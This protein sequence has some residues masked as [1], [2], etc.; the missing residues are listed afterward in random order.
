[1][2]LTD[3]RRDAARRKLPTIVFA[4]L[5]CCACVLVA[6]APVAAELTDA[7]A[8]GKLIYPEGKSQSNRG[9]R[10]SIG[11]AE[12]PSSATILPCVQCHGEN[13]RGIGIVTSKSL[14]AGSTPPRMA[15]TSEA[16]S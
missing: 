6:R 2:P 4:L 13:G 8:R 9:I 10:A 11:G 12:A 1:M 3:R 15:L 14:P 7:E 5:A 16:L